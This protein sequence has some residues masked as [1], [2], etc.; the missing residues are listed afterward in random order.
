MKD[1]SFNQFL[2]QSSIGVR[3][4]SV[5]RL[6]RVRIHEVSGAQAYEIDR[7]VAGSKGM[8]AELAV[9]DAVV[10]LLKGSDGTSEEIEL[11]RKNH[12]SST[13]AFIFNKG[14]HY[15]LGVDDT[16]EEIE[17][18]SLSDQNSDG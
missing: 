2:E 9:A 1:L 7:A 6:G 4:I 14:M 8:D 16:F 17:K 5:P 13:I 12:T 3:S 10:R 11:L 15:A 18:K